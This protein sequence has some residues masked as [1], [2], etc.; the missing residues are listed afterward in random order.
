[1]TFSL[2]LR[3]LSLAA[4]AWPALGW[5]ET[6]P[7]DP[8]KIEFFEKKIRPIL[9]DNCYNCHSANTNAKGGLR[10]DDRN[11]LLNGGS[12]GAAIVPGK[13]AA[14]LLIQ[15]VK[16]DGL[17]MPPKKRLSD[18][19]VADLPDFLAEDGPFDLHEHDDA[20]AVAAE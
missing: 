15:A 3:A 4:L 12:L 17:E 18:E 6:R 20:Y 16:H 11:G 9:V 13:P 2:W 7:D 19:Q 8:A 14:S 5:A 1:M 10:V